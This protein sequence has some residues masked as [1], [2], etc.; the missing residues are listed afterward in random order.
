M[1]CVIVDDEALAR[2]LLADYVSKVPEL[3][4]VGACD[5]AIAAKSLVQQ[6][7]V[8]LLLLDI[9]MPDLTGIELLKILPSP[10]ITIFTTAYAEY[11]LEGYNLA[12]IDY[13]LK[14]I[15]FERFFQAV[16]R[17]QEFLRYRSTSVP[18]KNA[19]VAPNS[20]VDQDYFFVKSDYKIVKINFAKVIFVEGMREY[21]RIHT[22]SQKVMTLLSMQKMEEMLP[23][24]MF[25]RIHRSHIVNLS[26]IDE[27]QGNT[28]YLGTRE[29]PVSKGYKE[30]FLKQINRLNLF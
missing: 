1:K 14:P 18:E 10:P 23:S 5:S 28:V 19:A 17:A 24:A 25:V 27:I 6:Q 16:T 13:L 29:L 7:E 9:Q 30:Q 26:K 21:V 20:V 15:S 12:V 2:R 22:E 3:E 11:A 4:L 8:D